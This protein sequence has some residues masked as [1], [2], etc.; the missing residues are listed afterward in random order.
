MIAGSSQLYFGTSV[1]KTYAFDD[2]VFSDAGTAIAV[3]VRTK[4]YYV[5][6]MD[7]NHQLQEINVFSDEPQ[8]TNLSVS[9]DGGDYDYKGQIQGD[10]N[11][12]VFPIWKQFNH[13]SIGLDEI[14][15]NNISVKGFVAYYA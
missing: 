5:Q 2:S 12:N 10:K 1:G 9:L 4:N 8:G 7:E 14:S 11:P 3:K 15:A 6:P 13:F